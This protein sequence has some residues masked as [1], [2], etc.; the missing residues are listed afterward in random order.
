VGVIARLTR[1]DRRLGAAIRAAAPPDVPAGRAAAAAAAVMSPAFRVLV[2]VLCIRRG[3]RRTGLRALVA[4]VLAATAARVLRDA[5]GRPRPGPRREGG[6]PSRHAAASAAIAEAVARDMPA[7]GAALRAAA[8]IGGFAR[9]ADGHHEPADIAAGG[10]LGAAMAAGV[11][12]A[13]DRM[14]RGRRPG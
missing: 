2:G 11:S 10:A 14:T 3:T 6:F 8:L 12:R 5:L 1:A 9:V 13:A 4:A 7:A